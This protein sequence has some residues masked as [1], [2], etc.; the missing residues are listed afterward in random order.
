[1]HRR[2]SFWTACL[3]AG[4]INARKAHNN[5]N[6]PTQEAGEELWLLMLA[7]SYLVAIVP[8]QSTVVGVS[9]TRGRPR[10]RPLGNPD[11]ASS[12]AAAKAERLDRS[13]QH[14]FLTPP[15]DVARV[16]VLAI[17]RVESWCGLFL[18]RAGSP[19]PPKAVTP[20][21]EQHFLSR[22]EAHL[23][24]LFS[25][26][27]ITYTSKCLPTSRRKQPPPSISHQTH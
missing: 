16:G 13:Y 14:W 26:S 8:S 21:A 3:P 24:L 17:E 7:P 4:V 2:S 23:L 9:N 20:Q 27:T 22:R 10:G 15:V 5:A 18:F 6:H 11:D 12:T 1:M 25:P 19:A